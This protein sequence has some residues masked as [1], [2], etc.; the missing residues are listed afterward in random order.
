VPLKYDD[1]PDSSAPEAERPESRRE[2]W[3]WCLLGVI[4]L[5]CGEVWMTRR[6]VKA[7]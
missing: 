5:L 1:D 3:W 6:L 7:R 2:V 4:A